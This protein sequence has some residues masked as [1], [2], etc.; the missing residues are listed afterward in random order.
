MP[1]ADSSG[2]PPA[3][4]QG[5]EGRASSISAYTSA[6]RLDNW[7]VAMPVLTCNL[8]HCPMIGGGICKRLAAISLSTCRILEGASMYPLRISG[9]IPVSDL[10]GVMGIATCHS[11]TCHLK[12]MD[13]TAICPMYVL[14]KVT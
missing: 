2:G 5:S 11:V 6:T 8:C 13:D 1:H 4:I 3:A 7:Y 12:G 9:G 10:V 14:V